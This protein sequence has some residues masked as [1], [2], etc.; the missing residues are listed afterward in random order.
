MVRLPKSPSRFICGRYFKIR[1]VGH[2]LD[3]DGFAFKGPLEVGAFVESDGSFVDIGVAEA[4]SGFKDKLSGFFIE[5]PQTGGV[6]ANGFGDGFHDDLQDLPDLQRRRQELT[7]FADA[8]EVSIESPDPLIQVG[9]GLG[10]VVSR[11]MGFSVGH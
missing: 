6:G 5:Q 2:I 10:R 9:G 1:V 3:N 8:G 7:G 11:C 4:V